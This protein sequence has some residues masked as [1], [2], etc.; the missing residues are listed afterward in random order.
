MT[1]KYLCLFYLFPQ[2]LKLQPSILGRR[3]FSL[4]GGD[5]GGS[6][7]EFLAIFPVEIGVVKQALLLVHWQG[8]SHKQAAQ[9]LGCT[10]ITISW[11][12][13]KARKLLGEKA[14]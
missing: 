11:R 14:A 6:L 1:L 4:R 2:H 8:L 13:H 5:G 12:I 9:I 3:Q 7:V 10:E